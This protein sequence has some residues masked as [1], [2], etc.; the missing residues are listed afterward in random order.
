MPFKVSKSCHKDSCCW[1]VLYS[2][3][4][5]SSADTAE[6]TRLRLQTI[7]D[8][9]H[10][11]ITPGLAAQVATVS[12][13]VG[14]VVDAADTGFDSMQD[15]LAKCKA[16]SDRLD[17]V[18]HAVDAIAEVWPASSKMSRR[19]ENTICRFTHTPRLRG[20]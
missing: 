3:P 19:T 14:A 13:G 5:Y 8:E 15:F 16:V 4:R 11:M 9:A 2:L 7:K 18:M 1:N 10:K 12:D 6:E 20:V 17:F